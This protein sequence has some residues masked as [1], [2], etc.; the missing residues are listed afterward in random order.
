MAKRKQSR[1]EALLEWQLKSHGIQHKM[2]YRFDKVRRWKFDFAFPDK[3]LAVEIEGGL[4]QNGRHNRAKGY[5]ADMEK[6]NAAASQGWTLLRFT[7]MQV[8][9][10][11]AVLEIATKLGIK[12]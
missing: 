2:E 6:Y 3:M 7:P 10:G 9:T 8:K 5:I 11:A 1:G 12:L 4:Y